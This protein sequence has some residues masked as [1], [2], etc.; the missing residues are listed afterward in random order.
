[1]VRL[2]GVQL[3][4]CVTAE[5]AA[6]PGPCTWLVRQEPES[7]P[8]EF[9][10]VYS[11][12]SAGLGN[13]L[14]SVLAFHSLQAPRGRWRPPGEAWPS[15][16]EVSA[17]PSFKQVACE[18]EGLSR[19]RQDTGQAAHTPSAGGLGSGGAAAPCNAPC[20]AAASA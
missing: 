14:R 12:T 5:V 2:A 15:S 1:M 16:G 6:R 20:C 10:W 4:S 17:A 9:C 11:N 8:K 18:W 13:E 19:F 3:V 7:L